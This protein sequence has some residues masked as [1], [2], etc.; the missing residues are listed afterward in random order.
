MAKGSTTTV[1][2]AVVAAPSASVEDETPAAQNA[3]ELRQHAA[4]EA[5][6]PAKI[7]TLTPEPEPLPQADPRW[8]SASSRSTAKAAAPHSIVVGVSDTNGDEEPLAVNA[9]AAQDKNPTAGISAAKPATAGSPDEA[10]TG[11]TR[12]GQ[13]LQAVTMRSK[14]SSRGSVLGTIPGRA[15]VEVVSCDSWCEIVYD[16]KRGFV[17]KRFLKNEGR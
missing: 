13:A 5:A 1:R 12:A 6:Q 8:T 15:E 2:P 4:P 7:A 14:P 10:G 11:E 9:F 17:Y 3:D 16:G